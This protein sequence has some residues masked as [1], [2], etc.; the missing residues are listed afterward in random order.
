MHHDRGVETRIPEWSTNGNLPPG[1]QFAAW[2]Q[3][4]EGSPF[5]PRRVLPAQLPGCATGRA[6]VDFF[7]VNKLTGERRA[8]WRF[9]CEGVGSDDQERE[10]VPDH[11][12]ASPAFRG[13]PRRTR[14]AGTPIEYAR[15][16]PAQRDAAESQLQEL[17]EQIDAYERLHM[18]NCK[19]LVLEAVE[20]CQRP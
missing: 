15:L 3:I 17:Q 18:G 6:F 11:E 20:D 5:I 7:Q 4:E 10:A 2:A 1:I 19:E 12:G 13:R 14:P 9:G 16:C 8:L